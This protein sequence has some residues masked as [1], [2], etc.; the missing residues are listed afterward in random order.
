MGT[1]FQ[2]CSS[3]LPLF[4]GCHS[5]LVGFSSIV[6]SLCLWPVLGFDFYC[7]IALTQYFPPHSN[8]CLCILCHYSTF[9]LIV[10]TDLLLPTNDTQV[11]VSQGQSVGLASWLP[12]ISKPLTLGSEDFQ[13]KWLTGWPG[14]TFVTCLAFWLRGLYLL[15]GN[16]TH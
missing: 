13:R 9:S 15:P 5:A 16:G 2:L 12:P 3:W 14:W 11:I 7:F 6:S 8:S 1:E 4:P 10:L